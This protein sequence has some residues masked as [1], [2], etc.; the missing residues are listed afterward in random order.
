MPVVV[1]STTCPHC[2]HLLEIMK[3]KNIRATRV[4]AD[5]SCKERKKCYKYVPVVELD[6]G[7][8][9]TGGEAIKWAESQ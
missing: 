2:H 8:V 3:K 9:L 5:K 6:D 1:Y 7:T 4:T